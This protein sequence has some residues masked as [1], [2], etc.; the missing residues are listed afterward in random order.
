MLF[1]R[2]IEPGGKQD[3]FLLLLLSCFTLKYD[4]RTEEHTFH[5]HLNSTY[6]DQETEV[7]KRSRNHPAAP[8]LCHQSRSVLDV[9]TTRIPFG[10]FLNMSGITLCAFSWA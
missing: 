5:K 2:P 8:C 9:Q 4:V 7:Y 3:L 1:Q 6:P 10:L